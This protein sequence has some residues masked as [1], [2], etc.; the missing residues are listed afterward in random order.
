MWTRARYE[1]MVKAKYFAPCTG[2][3]IL[4]MVILIY[5]LCFEGETCNNNSVSCGFKQ[6]RCLR[7]NYKVGN[8]LMTDERCYQ[9]SRC[10]NTAEIC[11]LVKKNGTVITDCKPTCCEKTNCNSNSM[12]IASSLLIAMFVGFVLVLK[13]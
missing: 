4:M 11:K 12:P 13:I 1:Y 10:S 9:S 7:I 8:D 6:D 3:F 2:D 5:Y